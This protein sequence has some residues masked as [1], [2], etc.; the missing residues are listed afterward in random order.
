MK[1]IYWEVVALQQRAEI[2][3]ELIG[4]AE[5]SVANAN[6]LFKGKEGSQLDV[7]QLE[8]DLERYR[9]D[10]EATVKIKDRAI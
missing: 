7:V 9:A 2:L 4:L 10:L 5:K 6:K 8:V 3:Q 1:N